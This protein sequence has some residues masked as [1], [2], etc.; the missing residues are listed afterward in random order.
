MDVHLRRLFPAAAVLIVA[1]V[2]FGQPFPG[3]PLN[4]GVLAIVSDGEQ[5]ALSYA[6]GNLASPERRDTLT[7]WIAPFDPAR[8]PVGRIEAPNS[9]FSPSGIAV[10]SRDQHRVY[11]VETM[12][13]RP[14]GMTRLRD[15][16][17]SNRLLAYDISDPAHPRAL[18]EVAVAPRP[19][20]VDAAA[21]GRTVVVLSNSADRPLAFVRTTER[22][23]AEPVR[24]AVPGAVPGIVDYGFVQ[25]SPTADAVAVHLNQENKIVFVRVERD[26]AGSVAGVRPWGTPVVT[27]KYPLVGRFAPDGR[28]YITSDVNWGPDVPSFWGARNGVLTLIRLA[29]ESARE[30]RHQV[31]AVEIAGQSAESFAISPDGQYVVASNIEQSGSLAAT[32]DARARLTLYRLDGE[33]SDLIKIGEERYAGLLP[34]GIAFD[35]DSRYLLVGV[36]EFAEDRTK[37]GVLVWRLDRQ[38]T[39]RLVQTGVRLEAAPGAH[40]ISVAGTATTSAHKA[41]D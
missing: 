21:D 16:Q 23:L 37:G 33:N 7:L 15:L 19:R 29:E 35:A 39:P 11:V 6:T 41:G 1:C 10:V 36:N 9:N 14:E 27:N 28:H 12:G 22:G 8:G 20:S 31:R 32:P 24:F 25:W 4:L 13:P 18:N 34:Q 30:P 3:I 5:D 2:A 38:P 17:P 40:T 26:A